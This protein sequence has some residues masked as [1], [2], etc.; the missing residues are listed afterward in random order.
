MAYTHIN[1]SIDEHNA[2]VTERDALVRKLKDETAIVCRVLAA[3]GMKTYDDCKP[4]SIDEHVT[5]LV[6]KLAV[7]TEA[8]KFYSRDRDFG[9][10]SHINGKEARAALEELSH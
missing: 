10:D 7:A 3:L 6:R 1:P 2:F 8:L 5:R 9:M 4:Y